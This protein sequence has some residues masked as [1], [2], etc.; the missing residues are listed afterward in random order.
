L[1]TKEKGKI[2]MSRENALKSI[3]AV[4]EFMGE[5]S[6][7]WNQYQHKPIPNSQ[8]AKE[9]AEFSRPE[10]IGTAYSQGTTLIEVAADYVFAV[11]RT[12]TEPAQTIAPWACTR[13]VL[14]TSALSLWF[15]D[16]TISADERAKRSFAFRYEGLEQQRKLAQST[17]GKIDPQLIT[18]RIN[19]VEQIALN[20]GYERVLDR[21]GNR[22]GIGQTMPSITDIV[23]K[24]LNKEQNYRLLSGMVHAHHWALQHFG[25]IKTH[26]D[27]M[28][29]ENVKGV[30]F[31]K[32]ISAENIF[33]LCTDSVT[34]L[35]QALL[36]NFKL[37]GYDAKP[38]A[39][40]ADNAI[41]KI[42]P[43]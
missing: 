39:I 36:M 1:Y 7:I 41:K 14:E 23:I 35:F 30:Y 24:M 33:F 10:S 20:L 42:Q 27:Q 43:P 8:A 40:A 5:T 28:V 13:G 12:L 31:E 11:T 16:T 25:F 38:L 22:I 29:F 32:H 17:N 15:L 4:N 3:K 18:S 34:S 6:V 26:E 21:N 9:L 37:F 2:A 19:E